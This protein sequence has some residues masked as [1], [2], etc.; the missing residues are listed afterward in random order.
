MNRLNPSE[1]LSA[2]TDTATA[3]C[4][5]GC[6]RAGCGWSKP[7]TWFR[8]RQAPTPS[9]R[10][11]GRRSRSSCQRQAREGTSAPESHCNARVGRYACPRSRG[12]CRCLASQ[13]CA[14]SPSRSRA[15]TAV[16]AHEIGTTRVSVLFHDGRTYDIEIVTDAAALVEKLEA[17]AGRIVRAPIAVPTVSNR[18][19]PASTRR[20]AE[21]VTL[22]FDGSDVRPAI[23]YAVAPGATP[24]RPLGCDHPVDRPVPPGARHFTLD[25]RLD[26][27]VLRP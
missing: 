26:V 1:K 9:G 20:F 10:A 12:E 3:A 6:G 27:R 7:S 16:R 13:R 22:A 24:R 5:S 21:R 15:Q 11:S 14:P 18:C 17:S 4:D 2:R 8:R 23:A 25:L 19:S